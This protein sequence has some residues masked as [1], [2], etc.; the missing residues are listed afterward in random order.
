MRVE[1]TFL[2]ALKE[3]AARRGTAF[4]RDLARGLRCTE[5]NLDQVLS[6]DR[7]HGMRLQTAE[8][9]AEALGCGVALIL[10]TQPRAEAVIAEWQEEAHRRGVSL[11]DLLSAYVE[12]SWHSDTVWTWKKQGF[13]TRVANALANAKIRSWSQLEALDKKQLLALRDLGK[14][15][16][17]EI[18]ER[19][20][21][22]R[23]GQAR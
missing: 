1:S 21:K 18:E 8:K 16:V 13:H 9:L 14:T 22:R 20:A 12:H 15:G 5:D 6:G 2:Q 11:W 17:R 19:L 10:T 3:E 23:E 7:K 4:R